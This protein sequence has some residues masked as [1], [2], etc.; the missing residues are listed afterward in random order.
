MTEAEWL[1]CTDTGRMVQ[2]LRGKPVSGRKFRLF[3]CACVRQAWHLLNDDRS[4]E[5]VILA[6]QVADG[7]LTRKRLAESSA[8]DAAREAVSDNSASDAAR[9]ARKTL[10]RSARMAASDAASMAGRA[11]WW[12]AGPEGWPAARKDVDRAQSA[13]LRDI[14]GT[15]AFRPL[16][17]VD[18]ACLSWNRG[19]VVRLA[20]AA[21]D[22]RLLPSGMLDN[23][24][25]AV[26]A[27]ALEEAGCAD[28]EI[29]AHLRGPG[30]H[31]RGCHVLDRLLGKP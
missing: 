18:S 16:P 30:P 4:R 25:L 7:E 14:F 2:F 29:L 28:A 31:A 13:L 6:E 21:Y 17:P 27:D 12:P 9:A 3:A 26:L 19:T 1:A 22:E 8:R 20:E 15:L 23:T 5:A 11:Q 24:R 10:V